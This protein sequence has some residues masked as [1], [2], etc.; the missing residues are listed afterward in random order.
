MHKNHQ[1]FTI[2]ELAIVLTIIALLVGGILAGSTAIKNAK[3]QSLMSDIETYSNAMQ[4]F[5]DKYHYLP[6]D[7]PDAENFWGSATGCPTPAYSTLPATKTCN[8]DGN[9][10]IADRWLGTTRDSELFTA[11]QQLSDAGFIKLTF[12]GMAGTGSTY[13]ALPGTNV[14]A[15]LYENG[16]YTV[17]YV[18][19]QN[20]T[21]DPNY[22]QALYNHM[23]VVGT[24][25]TGD[26][27]RGSFLLPEEAY[28][29]D[30]KMDDGLPA[31]G[32]VMT[33][34]SAI[35]P[36]C[37]TSDTAA[38]STYNNNYKSPA[39]GLFFLTGL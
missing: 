4:S 24:K 10:H 25:R 38:S 22:F 7:F 2:V 5:K 17:L 3:L 16:G 27:A 11:W 34:K 1:G 39:C 29:V 28:M 35:M 37:T 30:A 23:I 14:P 20:F 18:Q 26:Y 6:G 19:P 31:S 9:G 12:T 33:A 32:S 13:E 15:S 8:G 21:A 36:N